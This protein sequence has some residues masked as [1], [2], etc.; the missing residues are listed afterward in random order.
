[1]RSIIII[2][3]SVITI[4]NNSNN[5]SSVELIEICWIFQDFFSLNQD[6]KRMLALRKL[7]WEFKHFL[8]VF[9]LP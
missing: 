5:N 4:N 7:S 2:I 6:L 9:N 1:M 3:T 8:T